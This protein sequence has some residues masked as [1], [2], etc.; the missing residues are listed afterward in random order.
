MRWNSILIDSTKCWFR[1]LT[2]LLQNVKL[3]G[4]CSI[5][6][7]QKHTWDYSKSDNLLRCIIEYNDENIILLCSI[8]RMTYFVT[9]FVLLFFLS[10]K[11]QFCVFFFYRKPIEFFFLL[12]NLTSAHSE[13]KMEEKKLCSNNKIVWFLCF[14]ILE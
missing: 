7:V 11:L 14:I 5:I 6:D 12:S 13:R 9:I 2:F 10:I 3:K 8:Q 4:N 1:V